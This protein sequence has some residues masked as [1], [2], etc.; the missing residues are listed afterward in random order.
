MGWGPSPLADYPTGKWQCVPLQTPNTDVSNMS[1]LTNHRCPPGQVD[2]EIHLTSP[3]SPSLWD[4]T[5]LPASV[6]QDWTLILGLLCVH[7]FIR[8][9]LSTYC[10]GHRGY[11]NERVTHAPFLHLSRQVKSKKKKQNKNMKIL[12]RQ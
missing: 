9:S 12:Q 4:M 3:L 11:G 6:P 8:S 2:Q 1:G 7:L 10:T 5:S